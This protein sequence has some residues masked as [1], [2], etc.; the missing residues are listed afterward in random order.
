MW[1]ST[2]VEYVCCLDGA[3]GGGQAQGMNWKTW[4]SQ[5][6]DVQERKQWVPEA[7]KLELQE[8]LHVAE[9]VAMYLKME[10]PQKLE[11]SQFL[12]Q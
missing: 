9:N 6:G 4:C 8:S 12:L 11:V 10:E 3:A 1:N 7:A 2:G 5:I